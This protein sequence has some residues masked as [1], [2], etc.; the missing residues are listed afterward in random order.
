MIN[1]DEY[2]CC[3]LPELQTS[4]EIKLKERQQRNRGD[5]DKENTETDRKRRTEDRGEQGGF[6]P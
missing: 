5:T 2:N 3:I 1:W 4:A 6:E